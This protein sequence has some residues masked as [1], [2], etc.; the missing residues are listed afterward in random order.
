MA[1]STSEESG[2]ATSKC[3]PRALIDERW[4]APSAPS[5]WNLKETS[6][7]ADA[8]I[9]WPF[10]CDGVVKKYVMLVPSAAAR[11]FRVEID[12]SVLPRSTSLMTEEEI[13]ARS[14]SARI[15]KPCWV[16]KLRSRA[17]I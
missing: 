15:E 14:A 5:E 17:P 6:L 13:S 10:T 16:R 8:R 2:E 7:R 4:S 1:S 3:T 9:T 11:R 12:G